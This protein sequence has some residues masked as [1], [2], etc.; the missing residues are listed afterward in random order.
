MAHYE[1]IVLQSDYLPEGEPGGDTKRSRMERKR[2]GQL[3]SEMSSNL[4]NVSQEVLKRVKRVPAKSDPRIPAHLQS[5]GRLVKK[6]IL[7]LQ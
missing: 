4:V 5:K 7:Q 1:Q 3:Q 2:L 6:S